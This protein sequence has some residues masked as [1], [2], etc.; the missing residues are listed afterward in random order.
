MPNWCENDIRIAGPEDQIKDF[1][2]TVQDDSDEELFE[3]VKSIMPLPKIFKDRQAPERDEAVAKRAIEET[4]H[5]DWYNWANDDSNWG[6][7]WGDCDTYL[8]WDDTSKWINGSFTT[9]WGPISVAFWEKASAKFPKLRIAIGYREEGM[10]FEGAYSF[11]N[12]ECTYEHSANTSPYLQEAVEAVNRFAEEE[13]V[14]EEDILEPS[15][16]VKK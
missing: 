7:K 3:I 1:I 15:Y 16:E 2:K 11:T 9:A 13:T 5:S 10:A 12:G 14:Y 4:G 8:W 6:T